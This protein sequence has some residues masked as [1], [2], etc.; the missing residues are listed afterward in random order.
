MPNTT[1]DRLECAVAGQL[2]CLVRWL[3]AC[4]VLLP[5]LASCTSKLKLGEKRLLVGI[6]KSGNPEEKGPNLGNLLLD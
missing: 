3:V 6:S 2:Q 4:R 1:M 5:E